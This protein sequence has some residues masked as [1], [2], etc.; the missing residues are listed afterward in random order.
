[1]K[2]SP[3][4]SGAE[5]RHVPLLDAASALKAAQFRIGSPDDVLFLPEYDAESPAEIVRQHP[6]PTAPVPPTHRLIAFVNRLWHWQE[7]LSGQHRDAFAKI[8]G[9]D[10]L[11]EALVGLLTRF[12]VQ[13]TVTARLWAREDFDADFRDLVLDLFGFGA[14]LPVLGERERH[15]LF[16][17]LPHLHRFADQV[18]A[19][20]G[21]L[22]A[23]MDAPVSIEPFE[24]AVT[25]IDPGDTSLLGRRGS[26]LGRH[27][28]A[29]DSLV[30]GRRVVEA[31][32][33]HRLI[34]GNLDESEAQSLEES[35]WIRREWDDRRRAKWAEAPKSRQVAGH[36][37]PF[38][39][40]VV[41][42]VRV[43]GAGIAAGPWLLGDEG[44][45]ALGR[46]TRLAS[47]AGF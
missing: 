1:M 40:D 3:A 23:I 41:W 36:L 30:L 35:G 9:D 31:G 8:G 19:S 42:E 34:V 2:T 44:R 39:L 12:R 28:D 22:S 21:A 26:R 45:S 29:G 16:L 14:L 43:G 7:A 27:A 25:P 47:A 5:D 11:L 10:L 18:M 33:R 37:L 4:I 46:T 32:S 17:V 20:A 15:R 6:A 24:P 38:W 13:G